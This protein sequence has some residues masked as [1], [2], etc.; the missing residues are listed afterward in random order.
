MKCA[1]CGKEIKEGEIARKLGMSVKE[2]E[3]EFAILRHLELVKGRKEG[4]EV[5]IVPFDS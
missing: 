3:R 2:V 5:F 4:D 1:K